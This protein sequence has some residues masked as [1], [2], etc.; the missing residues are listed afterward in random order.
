[1]PPSK[2][3]TNTLRD[4]FDRFD[5]PLEIVTDNAAQLTSQ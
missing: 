5:L 3:L 2:V 1:M 4:S